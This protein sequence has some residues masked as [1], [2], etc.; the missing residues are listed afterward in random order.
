MFSFLNAKLLRAII[1]AV[2]A[3][4][5]VGGAYFAGGSKCK[6][7]IAQANLKHERAMTDLRDE[8]ALKHAQTVAGLVRD[9]AN[10][11]KAADTLVQDLAMC[12]YSHDALSVFNT[13]RA[14]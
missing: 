5:L 1:Y 8:L 13:L 9:R 14:N 4:A 10:L 7:Q 6:G 2:L 12:S 11:L 3:I